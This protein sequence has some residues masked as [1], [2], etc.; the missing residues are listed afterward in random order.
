MNVVRGYATFYNPFNTL[1]VIRN[2]RKDRLAAKRLMFL[3]IGQI[4]LVMTAPKLWRWAR[5]LKK[6]P[7]KVWDGLIEAPIPM[8]D[9]HTGREVYW[10]VERIPSSFLPQ[11][12]GDEAP[13]QLDSVPARPTNGEGKHIGLPIAGPQPTFVAK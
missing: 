11:T 3:I 13:T 9:A 6:G 12:P 10:A 5:R 4:G 2:W 7:I 1:R 8:I